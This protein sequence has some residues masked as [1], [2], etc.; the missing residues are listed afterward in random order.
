MPRLMHVD[1]VRPCVGRRVRVMR[2]HAYALTPV[3]SRPWAVR[4]N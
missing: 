2:L 1:A 4:P 3:P